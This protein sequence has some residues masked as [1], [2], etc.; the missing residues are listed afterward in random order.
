M[1][2]QAVVVHQEPNQHHHHGQQKVHAPDY[3][4]QL[5]RAIGAIWMTLPGAC[6]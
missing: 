1:H 4:R 5:N 6:A 3:Q 2:E